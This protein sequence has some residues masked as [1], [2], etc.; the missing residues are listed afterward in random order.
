VAGQFAIASMPA[1]P[2]GRPSATLGGAALAINAFSDRRDDAY[3]LID[4]LLQ[5]EQMIERAEVAGQ[6]PP[7]RAIYD[8]RALDEALAVPAVEARAIIERA[9]P[10]PASPVYSE[11]S[12]IL[13][14]SLHRALT[15]QQEPRAALQEAAAA[16]RALLARAGLAGGS[17]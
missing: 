17:S 12:E 3:R 8:T 10:R 11:L 14:V 4:F 1:G 6:F 5:P 16:M 13:Q 15:G 7:V 9:V 2:G